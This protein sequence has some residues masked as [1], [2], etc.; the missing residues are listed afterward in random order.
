MAKKK[1]GIKNFFRKIGGGIK[2]AVGVVGK[3]GGG[4]A[5]LVGSVLPGPL[6]TAAKSV[7]NLLSPV[8]VEKIVDAVEQSGVVKVDKIEETVIREGGTQADAVKVAEVL[9]PQIAMYTGAKVDDTKSRANVTTVSKFKSLMSKPIVWLVLGI[10][11]YLLF[12]NKKR[13]GFR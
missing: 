4:A 7:G 3:I 1:R 2:K 6:G 10:T 5:K 9:T 11:G 13:K 12:F 8:K